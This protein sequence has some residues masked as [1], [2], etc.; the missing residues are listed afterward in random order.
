ME[1]QLTLNGDGFATFWNPAAINELQDLTIAASNT[2]W[3]GDINHAYLSGAGSTK[4]GTIGLSV[5]SL[6]TGPMKRRTEWA[7]DGTGEYFAASNTAVGFYLCKAAY[8]LV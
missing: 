5:T 1:P 4:I 3:A 2:F 7:P 8:R 6:T